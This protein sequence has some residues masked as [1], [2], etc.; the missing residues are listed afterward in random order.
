VCRRASAPTVELV[1]GLAARQERLIAHFGP[2]TVDIATINRR[3]RGVALL[4]VGPDG[5]SRPAHGEPQPQAVLISLVREWG[6]HGRPAETGL[7]FGAGY[8]DRIGGH[9]RTAAEA[10][11]P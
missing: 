9:W 7:A 8:G 4:G 2:G 11:P 6:T 1:V 10:T 3:G 5:L